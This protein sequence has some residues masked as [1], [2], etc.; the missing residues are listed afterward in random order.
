MAATWESDTA[1]YVVHA[2]QLTA[3]CCIAV[4]LGMVFV[5]ACGILLLREIIGLFRRSIGMQDRRPA[6]R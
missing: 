4:V 3:F 6:H 5:A 1:N 2:G